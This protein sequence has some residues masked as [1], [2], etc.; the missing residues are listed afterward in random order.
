[1]YF[2]ASSIKFSFLLFFRVSVLYLM[3]LG[4]YKGQNSIK[5][6]HMS[7][8]GTWYVITEL[9]YLLY[10]WLK[11]MKHRWSICAQKSGVKSEETN[12]LCGQDYGLCWFSFFLLL[13]LFLLTREAHEHDCHHHSCSVC[14]GSH[15]YCCCWILHLQTEIKVREKNFFFSSFVSDLIL[16]SKIQ[17]SWDEIKILI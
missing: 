16:L 1:M 8:F 5:L 4:I 9:S 7:C 14:S 10:I 12:M 17:Q 15:S 13:S 6:M 11:C 3:S 2:D